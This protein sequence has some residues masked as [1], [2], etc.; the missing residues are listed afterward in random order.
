MV[1]ENTYIGTFIYLF[2]H[3]AGS[4]G[5]DEPTSFNLTQQT[6]SDR[7]VGDLLSTIGGKSFIFEFKRSKGG[8]PLELRKPQRNKLL[9]FLFSN[10]QYLSISEKMH[11][12]VYP[13]N[14]KFEIQPYSNIVKKDVSKVRKFNEI[15]LDILKP[16]HPDGLGAT[17]RELKAYIT[18]LNAISPPP[19]GSGGGHP[20]ILVNYDKDKNSLNFYEYDDILVL[21]KALTL[22]AGNVQGL[23]KKPGRGRG[24]GM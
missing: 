6:P 2:G 23:G 17:Y 15:A 12:I 1:Y 16:N 3:C 10:R 5:T 18:L 24:V 19:K 20:A 22:D 8:I 4:N 7:T 13:M 14:G 9:S 11:F 21:K